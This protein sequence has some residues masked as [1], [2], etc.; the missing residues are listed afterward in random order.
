MIGVASVFFVG[1]GEICCADA[2]C[3]PPCNADRYACRKM[4]VALGRN[5]R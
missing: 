5:I 3:P 2:L 4:N 1:E